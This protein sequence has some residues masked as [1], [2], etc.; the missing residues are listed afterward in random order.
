M[1]FAD[2]TAPVNRWLNSMFGGGVEEQSVVKNK[3]GLPNVRRRQPGDSLDPR[4]PGSPGIRTRLQNEQ[5]LETQEEDRATIGGIVGDFAGSQNAFNSAVLDG[6]ILDSPT[7]KM[8]QRNNQ[9]VA[10]RSLKDLQSKVGAAAGARG[11]RGGGHDA[12]EM[13]AA[14]EALATRLNADAQLAGQFTDIFTRAGAARDSILGSLMNTQ[15]NAIS[16]EE[17]PF[18][19]FYGEAFDEMSLEQLPQA[20]EDLAN[21]TDQSGNSLLEIPAIRGVYDFL[22]IFGRLFNDPGAFFGER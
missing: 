19:D 16:N 1:L 18:R 12:L 11:L 21:A 22:E 10:A 14:E 17:F 3:P 15:I 4:T 9:A 2:N 8:M 5:F 13:Q 6:S 7:F 20:L